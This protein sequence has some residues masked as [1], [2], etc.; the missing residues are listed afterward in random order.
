MDKWKS[1]CHIHHTLF[2]LQAQQEEMQ[3]MWTEGESHPKLLQRPGCFLIL[4]HVDA[5]RLSVCDDFTEL[6]RLT[7]SYFDTHVLSMD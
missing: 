7:R 6:A 4:K 3:I 1:G 2:Q 5:L